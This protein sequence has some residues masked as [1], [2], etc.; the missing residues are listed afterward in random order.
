M[1]GPGQRQLQETALKDIENRLAA[2]EVDIE[3]RFGRA[4]LLT[5]L[6]RVEEAKAAYIEILKQSPAHFGALNNLATLLYTTGFRTAARTVYAETVRQHPDNPAGHVNLANALL[7]DGDH[8]AARRHYETALALAP[9][10]AEAHQGFA[11]LLMETGEDEAAA[12]HQRA[13]FQERPFMALPYR[14]NGAAIPILL[15]ISAVGGNIP[16]QRFLDDRLFQT[17]V[18]VAEFYDPATKLPPH[19]LI[20]NSI[21]DADLCRDALEKA[22][23]LLAGTAAPVINQPSAVLA[24]GRVDNAHRFSGAPGLVAPAMAAMRRADLAA[25]DALSLLAE[26]GFSFPF[27]LRTPGFHTGRHF[28]FVENQDDLTAALKVLPGRDITLIQYLDARDKDGKVRKYRAMFIGGRIYP[29]HVAISQHWKVHYFTAE[30][31]D[32]P[33]HRAEDA[34]FLND[35]P[36]VLGA[37]AMKA[38]EYISSKL[39]LDYAGIDFGLNADG[40][41]LLFET[42]ATMVVNPPEP[43]ARWTYRRAAFDR[44]SDS[45]NALLLNKADFK[46]EL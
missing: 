33:E 26:K 13:A 34:A 44:L 10:H 29:L 4:R 16:L 21:G 1:N 5:E 6:N 11:N 46:I 15:L 28:Y 12:R 19:R 25:P 27:L 14:G 30:M 35:M 37:R 2:G 23:I 8:A 39:G 7:V 38:L 18:I 32:N 22:K 41:V 42:N 24:T 17:T 31:A 43:D 9:Q 3:L 36:G 45:I 40:D 20:V